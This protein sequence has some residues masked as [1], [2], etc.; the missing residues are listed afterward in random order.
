MTF[1]RK[2]KSEGKEEGRN[3]DFWLVSVRRAHGLLWESK[4]V[5][6]PI[7]EKFMGT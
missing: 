6:G 5:Y 7:A 3:W 4:N 2:R 1:E